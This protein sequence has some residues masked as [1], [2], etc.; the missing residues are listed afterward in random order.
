MAQADSI[1]NTAPTSRNATIGAPTMVAPITHED[2]I[3]ALIEYHRLAHAA[4]EAVFKAYAAADNSDPPDE[5]QEQH[6]Q[7]AF[8]ALAR[9]LNTPPTTLAGVAAVLDYLGAEF[10][11]E[12]HNILTYSAGHSFVREEAIAFLPMIAATA[13]RLSV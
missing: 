12:D 10:M 8:D 3:F 4:H 13:A 9:V 2:P 1:T 7:I 11:E 5:L 6:N